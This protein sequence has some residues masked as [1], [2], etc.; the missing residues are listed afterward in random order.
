MTPAAVRHKANRVRSVKYSECQLIEQFTGGQVRCDEIRDDVHWDR[1]ESGTVTGY[2][3][4]FATVASV[5]PP[6][7]SAK[8]LEEGVL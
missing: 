4:R 6:T 2:R 5:D 7:D 1:D 3:V 8:P